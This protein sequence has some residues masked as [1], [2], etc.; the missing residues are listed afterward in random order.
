MPYFRNYKKS[1]RRNRKLS[2]A[3]IY[4]NRGAK[5][6]SRQIA[7]LNSKVN[8]LSRLT[9]PE[10][11][12][13]IYKVSYTFKNDTFS[14]TWGLVPFSPWTTTNM[15]G[16]D[17]QNN[18][19]IIEGTF[20][21][22]RSF[23]LRL[24]AQYSDNHKDEI[25][26]IDHDPS[27]GYRIIVAQAKNAITPGATNSYFINDII[28]TNSSLYSADEY[29]LMAPLCDGIKS[30][31]RILMDKTYPNKNSSFTIWAVICHCICS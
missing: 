19:S 20:A 15:I 16:G 31:Y 4:A 23:Q 7:K 18:D 2:K 9:K 21:R 14:N 26:A 13:R 10:V 5:A 3:Y 6:Q 1:N 30:Q 25:A 29:N 22:A 28:M 17:G 24:I 12:C 11:L 27:A 8:R